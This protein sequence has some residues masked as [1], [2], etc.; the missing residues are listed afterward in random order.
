MEGFLGV[1]LFLIDDVVR[2]GIDMRGQ[3]AGNLE[4]V[5]SIKILRN[6]AKWS[7]VWVS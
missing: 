6:P 2:Y 1:V 5:Q 7:F 4:L 3:E